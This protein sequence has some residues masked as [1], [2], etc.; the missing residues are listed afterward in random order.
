MNSQKAIVIGASSGIGKELAKILAR[1]NYVVGI[2]GRR[3]HL[4]EEL[5]KELSASI[6]VKQMDISR[7]QEAITQLKELIAE[8]GG[9]DL[10]IINAGIGFINPD[11]ELEKEQATID[12]NVSGF[13]AM[14]TM[15]MKYFLAQKSGHI[16]AI[17]SVAA[18]RGNRGAP[19]YD[20]S[21]AFMSNYMEGLRTFAAHSGFPIA[22]TDIKPGFVD[23]AMAQGEHIFWQASAEK[24]ATQ[25]FH[26]IKNKRKHAYITRRW[27]IIAWLFRNIPD[28]IYDRL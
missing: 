19:A 17:S 28:F 16:V 14:A 4:L 12:V 22:T 3:I 11:L 6:F 1:N 15:A 8:I 10:I 18:L 2:T 23:T 25:I 7:T 21:K 20:A 26:A 27:R 13:V 24:A 9:M 5:Q